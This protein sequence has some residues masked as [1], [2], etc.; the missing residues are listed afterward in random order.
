MMS[1]MKI[2]HLMKVILLSSLF[3]FNSSYAEEGKFIDEG[4]RTE[5]LL[6]AEEFIIIEIREDVKYLLKSKNRELVDNRVFG[7][8]IHIYLSPN[9]NGVIDASVVIPKLTKI[10]DSEFMS[11]LDNLK[12]ADNL[13]LYDKETLNFP[14][15][16]DKYENTIRI[17]VRIKEDGDDENFT[18]IYWFY[19]KNGRWIFAGMTCVG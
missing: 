12:I 6:I 18:K 10:F 19:K 8:C 5:Q 13:Y 4:F 9:K 17:M 7:D 11:T 2:Q 1:D 14:N 15:Y 3:I 16:Q